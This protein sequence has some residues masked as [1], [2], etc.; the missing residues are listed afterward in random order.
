MAD[1]Y[2]IQPFISNNL[3]WETTDLEVTKAAGPDD[4]VNIIRTNE[5]FDVT[6][7]FQ[8][9]PAGII[10]NGYKVSNLKYRVRYF[11]ESMGPGS[12]NVDLG[13]HDDTLVVGTDIYTAAKTTFTVPAGTLLAGVYRLSATL[14]FPTAPGHA[15][16][17]EGT[18]LQVIEP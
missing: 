15:G 14:T 8:G 17:F 4:P 7:T 12:N 6:L 13:F 18:L 9:N 11:A 1:I 2:P 10:F 16:F 5:A 3:A